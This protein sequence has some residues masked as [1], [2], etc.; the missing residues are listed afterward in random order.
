M[1]IL[2]TLGLFSFFS[3]ILRTE[4]YSPTTY[5]LLFP[6]G[7]FS[8]KE[9]QYISRLLRLLVFF[10]HPQHPRQVIDI[11]QRS[12]APDCIPNISLSPLGTG[13]TATADT[14]PLAPWM[15]SCI[16]VTPRKTTTGHG[17]QTQPTSYFPYLCS[18]KSLLDTIGLPFPT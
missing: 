18:N 15:I 9:H 1:I 3:E 10:F 16:L 7:H 17:L 8:N 5:F 12:H 6:S 13:D 4:I 2:I 14:V 11:T